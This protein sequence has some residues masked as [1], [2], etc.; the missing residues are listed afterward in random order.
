M[1]LM[2]QQFDSR[3]SIS[4]CFSLLKLSSPPTLAG[5]ADH[6]VVVVPPF[7]S[8]LS[9]LMAA[10]RQLENQLRLYSM[11]A[12]DLRDRGNELLARAAAIDKAVAAIRSGA[13]TEQDLA[14]VATLDGT[15]T[16][17]SPSMAGTAANAVA[18]TVRI[19]NE[20]PIT[21]RLV[22]QEDR[23]IDIPSVTT[24][25]TAPLT[26]PPR[27]H[28]A[29]DPAMASAADTTANNSPLMDAQ[30][31]D[32][33]DEDVAKPAARASTVSFTPSTVTAQGATTETTRPKQAVSTAVNGLEVS[34]NAHI[35]QRDTQNSN[36]TNTSGSL[37]TGPPPAGATTTLHGVWSAAGLPGGEKRH[38]G[39]HAATSGQPRQKYARIEQQS[40]VL[41]AL[42]VRQIGQDIVE[43]QIASDALLALAP[44]PSLTGLAPGGVCRDQQIA[45]EALL[46]LA[47]GPNSVNPP[48]VASTDADYVLIRKENDNI[49]ASHLLQQISIIT[50]DECMAGNLFISP[51]DVGIAPDVVTFAMA[52][53]VPCTLTEDN[54][55]GRY[56]HQELKYIGLMCRHC[57]G[58]PGYGK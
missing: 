58:Q 39:D 32:S 8:Q 19:S 20:A 18:T 27:H 51:K 12:Q 7:S 17:T 55:I 26:T 45:S 16:T 2:W 23:R 57:F 9:L 13:A 34:L 5:R 6:H 28:Y 54:R 56:K 24:T 33:E 11:G 21:P 48:A 35:Q 36:N 50:W 29:K 30:D 22:T 41:S 15:T 42:E 43:Q 14:L 49:F 44:G 38:I 40:A 31:D 10:S 37:P 25:T 47:P 4:L 53:C 52:Q 1:L 3:P 46:T